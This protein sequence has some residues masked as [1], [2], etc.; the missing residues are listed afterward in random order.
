MMTIMKIVRY[1]VL[2]VFSLLAVQDSQASQNDSEILAARQKLEGLNQM[3]DSLASTLK[4]RKKEQINRGIFAQVCMPVGK[5][6]KAWAESKGYMARQISKKNRNPKH[7]PRDY[8]FATYAEFENNPS[9]MEKLVDM[10]V[11]GRSGRMFYYRI[12]VAQSCLSCHGPQDQRPSFVLEKYPE[13]KAFGF[14]VGD[15]RGLYSVFVPDETSE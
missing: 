12:P 3:R 11:D 4:N 5:S 2:L 10:K 6:F 1:F 8:D 14:S 13:D 7:F 15:L 9:L